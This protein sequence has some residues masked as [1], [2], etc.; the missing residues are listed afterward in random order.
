MLTRNDEKVFDSNPSPVSTLVDVMRGC[1]DEESFTAVLVPLLRTYNHVKGQEVPGFEKR[2]IKL[3]L[4]AKGTATRR[5]E[6][7]L[8]RRDEDLP[9]ESR[10]RAGICIWSIIMYSRACFFCL[11]S[12][13]SGFGPIMFVGMVGFAAEKWMT[14]LILKL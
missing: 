12:A 6:I 4:I 7:R 5:S 13:S 8:H 9:I 3:V 1:G 11:A 14:E 2:E 10:L